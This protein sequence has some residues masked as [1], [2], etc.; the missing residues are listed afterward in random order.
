MACAGHS[1]AQHDA[2]FARAMQELVRREIAGE[3]PGCTCGLGQRVEVLNPDGTCT[4]HD[5]GCPVMVTLEEVAGA[6]LV[7][8]HARTC[9]DCAY[10]G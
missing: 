5:D 8:V 3:L 1:G 9:A 4:V 2:A 6:A 10:E 7:E